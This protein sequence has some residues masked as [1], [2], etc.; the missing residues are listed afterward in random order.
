MLSLRRVLDECLSVPTMAYN[1]KRGTAA[2]V[3][4]PPSPSLP[5]SLPNSLPSP[6]PPFFHPPVSIQLLIM[7]G[8]H[9]ESIRITKNLPESLTIHQYFKASN[10]TLPPPHLPPFSPPTPILKESHQNEEESAIL[11]NP[12]VG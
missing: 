4:L 1:E 5:P 12:R 6:P 9:K 10:G 3:H 8:N 11:K 2:A 7:H